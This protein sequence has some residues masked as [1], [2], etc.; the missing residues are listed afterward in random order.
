MLF[1]IGRDKAEGGNR[2]L[3]SFEPLTIQPNMIHAV[4]LTGPYAN[5]LPKLRRRV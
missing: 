2:A 1:G 5:R 4:V 3:K